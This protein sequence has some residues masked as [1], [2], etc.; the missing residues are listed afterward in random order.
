M[1]ASNIYKA[2]IKI[3]DV[4]VRLCNGCL[5]GHDRISTTTFDI[6]CEHGSIRC[7]GQCNRTSAKIEIPIA[8]KVGPMCE[9]S[10]S[11]TRVSL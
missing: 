5:P 2:A 7:M 3:R 4:S 6:T 1:I 9:V 11:I 8:L 10:K